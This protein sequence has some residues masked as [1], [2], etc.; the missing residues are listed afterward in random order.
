MTGRVRTKSSEKRNTCSLCSV[1]SK[2]KTNP[3]HYNLLFDIRGDLEG[4]EANSYRATLVAQLTVTQQSLTVVY[5]RIPLLI[6]QIFQF[7]YIIL[8][9]RLS[10]SDVNVRQN[11]LDYSNLGNQKEQYLILLL[12]ITE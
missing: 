4:V 5:E 12:I 3:V 8:A 10:F 2:K 6:V 9:F 1:T 11:L 7:V